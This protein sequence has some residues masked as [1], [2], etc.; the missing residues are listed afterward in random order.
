MRFDDRTDAGDQLADQL[1]D[2]GV[3]ADLVCAIPRGGL[4]VGRVVADRLGVPLDVVV[5]VKLGAPSNPELALGAVAG[6]G[7]FWLNDSLVSRLGVDKDYIQRTR[8][9]E[10]AVA[11]DKVASYR[12]GDSLPDVADK[13]VILVDDGVATGATAIACLRQLRAGGAARVVLAV[14]VSPPTTAETLSDEAD[15][16][17]AV[18]VPGRFRAVGYHYRQFDQVTDEEAIAYLA[19][20]GRRDT[21]TG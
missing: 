21:E 11:S 1:L 13:R 2:A 17:L 19:E 15:Q 14:P 3:D 5:A 8:E 12:G 18:R 10:A 4:P 7:S 16:V 9:A 6:D 20:N